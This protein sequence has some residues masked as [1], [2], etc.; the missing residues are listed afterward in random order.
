MAEKQQQVVS[1]SNLHADY[2]CFR[3]EAANANMGEVFC[4]L[5]V[6]HLLP[7]RKLKLDKL[8]GGFA[9]KLENEERGQN[10]QKIFLLVGEQNPKKAIL[11][12]PREE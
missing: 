3:R 6:L 4:K 1:S 9:R 7:A 8:P 10:F 5:T 12:N 11:L 2:S